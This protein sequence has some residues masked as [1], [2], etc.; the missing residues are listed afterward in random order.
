MNKTGQNN[1]PTAKNYCLNFSLNPKRL[2]FLADELIGRFEA[3]FNAK[4][5][6]NIT[7]SLFHSFD[8][9]FYYYHFP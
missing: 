5:K 2:Y 1:G 7:A 9:Y 4:N 8:Y 3:M 6:T